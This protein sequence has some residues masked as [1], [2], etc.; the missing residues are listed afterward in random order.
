MHAAFEFSV[1]H[2][3]VTKEWRINSN[4]LVVVAVPDEKALRKLWFAA[5]CLGIVSTLVEEP[6]Y[7]NQ[8]TALTLEPG[9][10]ARTLLAEYPLALKEKKVA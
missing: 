1:D 7:G 5:D 10:M 3:D 9:K 6:D 2:P 8:A 4:F